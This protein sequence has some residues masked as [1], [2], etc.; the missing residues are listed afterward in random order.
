MVKLA[1]AS[2]SKS[3]TR[4]GVWVQ[5][6]LPAPT[7]ASLKTKTFFISYNTAGKKRGG[8]RFD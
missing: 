1:D 6:P 7:N 2:D 4:K 8:N 5:V 3:D